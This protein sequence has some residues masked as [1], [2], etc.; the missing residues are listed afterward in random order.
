MHN[1]VTTKAALVLIDD[2]I[3]F[4]TP[5]AGDSISPHEEEVIHFMEGVYL[6]MKNDLGFQQK[7]ISYAKSCPVSVHHLRDEPAWKH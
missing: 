1:E 7:M 6:M 4:F 2:Q 5:A 3:E